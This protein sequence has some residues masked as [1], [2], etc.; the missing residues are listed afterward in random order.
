[1]IRR[2]VDVV[3]PLLAVFL[4][5]AFCGFITIYQPVLRV[6]YDALASLMVFVT[7]A[8][9]FWHTTGP[10]ILDDY[11]HS[12]LALVAALGLATPWAYRRGSSPVSGLTRGSAR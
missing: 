12:L 5:A 6:V 11:R 8:G 10:S 3:V 9:R 1:L 2:V 4:A 7:H